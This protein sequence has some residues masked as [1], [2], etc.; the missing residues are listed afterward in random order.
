MAAPATSR[1]VHIDIISDTVCPWCWV[2]ARTH[3]RAAT[4]MRGAAALS[5]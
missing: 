5:R 1:A 3:E 2:G 4:A